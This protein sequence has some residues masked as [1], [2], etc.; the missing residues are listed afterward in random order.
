M[1]AKES[2][3]TTSESTP[4][5]KIPVKKTRRKISQLEKTLEVVIDKF[6]DS[7]KEMEERYL[8]LEEKRMKLEAENER[9]LIEIEE[10]RRE[11]ERQHELHLWQIMMQTMSPQG[12]HGPFN[13]HVMGP[14]AYMNHTQNTQYHNSPN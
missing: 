14:P 4:Q 2:T 10:N 1:S 8:D 11:R 6:M 7:Q 3:P 12:Y 5:K 13:G 9:K